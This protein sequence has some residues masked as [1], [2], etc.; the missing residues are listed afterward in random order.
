MNAFLSKPIEP[1]KLILSLRKHVEY[2]RERAIMIDHIEVHEGHKHAADWP[3]IIGITNSIDLFQG[4]LDLFEFS[5]R[6]LFEEHNDLD[7]LVGNGLSL[8]DQD[9]RNELATKVHKL[10]GSAGMVGAKELYNMASQAEISLRKGTQEHQRELLIDIVNGLQALQK[11]SEKFLDLQLKSKLA[12]NKQSD[13]AVEKMG[14]SEVEKLIFA[15]ENND[16]SVI[17]IVEEQT[18]SIVALL[19]EETFNDFNH[20]VTSLNYAKV[21]DILKAHNEQ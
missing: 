18:S 9:Y 17:D 15:L 13:P 4:D 12:S 14:S 2:Y 5:L 16:L 7:S 8:S 20:Q 3:E 10:R 1:A 19:G 21:A 11:N 6:R